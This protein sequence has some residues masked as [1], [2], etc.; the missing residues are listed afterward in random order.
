MTDRQ[1]QES[2]ARDRAFVFDKRLMADLRLAPVEVI[3]R[4][5]ASLSGEVRGDT[6]FW[7]GMFAAVQATPV[8][9]AE[10][11]R[12]R[13]G[14]HPTVT[15]TFRRLPDGPERLALDDDTYTAE[16]MK[17]AGDAMAAVAELLA[18]DGGDAVFLATDGTDRVLLEQ[19]CE[20]SAQVTAR[21]AKVPPQSTTRRVS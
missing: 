8:G 15:V 21:S 4:L 12:L 17:D 1:I 5:A 16:N 3:Q 6:V 20:P 18:A 2:A 7:S 9:I 11:L 13:Y 14:V 19:H 10:D